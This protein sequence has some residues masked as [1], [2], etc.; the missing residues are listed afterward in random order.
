[1]EQIPC[2]GGCEQLKTAELLSSLGDYSGL[3]EFWEALAKKETQ[4]WESKVKELPDGRES[5][6]RFRFCRVVKSSQCTEQYVLPHL[7]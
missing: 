2:R 3:D 4:K 7:P 1:M 6:G 5:G